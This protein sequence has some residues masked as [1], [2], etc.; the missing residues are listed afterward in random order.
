MTATPTN[1]KSYYS[2]RYDDGVMPE[3]DPE[4]LK[5]AELFDTMLKELRGLFRERNNIYRSRFRDHGIAGVLSLIAYKIQWL[6]SRLDDEGDLSHGE[7]LTEGF[8]D[9]AVYSALGALLSHYGEETAECK[10]LFAAQA[11]KNRPSEPDE[12]WRCVLCGAQAR[13]TEQ[14]GAS[15]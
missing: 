7:D 9:L 1:R 10:H 14:D 8:L 13:V 5:D 4:L 6:S 2:L 15:S 11:Y 12:P 3:V